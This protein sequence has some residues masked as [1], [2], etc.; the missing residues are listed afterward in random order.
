MFNPSNVVDV[1]A[2]ATQAGYNKMMPGGD[3]KTPNSLDLQGG[4]STSILDQK[5]L[6]DEKG[7]ESH[8]HNPG[9]GPSGG[10]GV[11]AQGSTPANFIFRAMVD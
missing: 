6:L 10:K 1:S 5:N 3:G 11:I 8:L 9:W 7:M 2:Y 4:N